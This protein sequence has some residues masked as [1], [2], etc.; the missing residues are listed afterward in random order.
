MAVDEIVRWGGDRLRIGRWQG[1][2]AIAHIAPVPGAP[3]SPR[4]VGATSDA[5]ARRGFRRVITSALTPREQQPFL[6]AGFEV[7]EQLHLLAHD[8]V[9]LPEPP[10]G[11]ALRRARRGDIDSVLALDH[12]AFRP[13]WRLD[14][15]GLQDALRAT[16]AARFRVA[17]E[18]GPVGYAVSGR[19]GPVGY[20]QRLAVEPGRHGSGLGTALVVDGLG[21]MRR[22]GA[23]RALVNTQLDNERALRLY[24]QLGFA[25]EPHRLAVLRQ[26]LPTP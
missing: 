3:P 19:A 25:P 16:P 6:D 23:R 13:F 1:D 11:I 21:W 7:H 24:R 22:R 5:L 10:P 20:L 2:D 17:V 26:E 15:A 9:H 14:H 12:R 8:L 18:A 4:A